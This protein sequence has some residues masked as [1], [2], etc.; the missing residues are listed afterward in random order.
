MKESGMTASGIS[1]V[2]GRNSSTVERF[3]IANG[4]TNEGNEVVFSSFEKSEI[5][6]LYEDERMNAVEVW[7][8]MFVNKCCKETVERYIRKTGMSRG[9]GRGSYNKTIVHDYFKEIDTPNKAYILGYTSA[10]GSVSSGKNV[11]FELTSEDVEILEFIK[12]E[13][14]INTSIHTYKREGRNDTCVLYASSIDLVKDLERYHVVTNKQGK[15]FPIPDIPEEYMRDFIR[16]YFDGDGSVFPRPDGT[17]RASICCSETFAFELESILLN[18]GILNSE[19]CNVVDMRKYGINI[20]SIRIDNQH[21]VEKFAKYIYRDNH[22]SLSR[23]R[24]R[25]TKHINRHANTEI[26]CS[27][28]VS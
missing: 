7:Q 23:K 8:Q 10:D 26:T 18:L 6:R 3:L 11:R 4:F 24:D 5:K 9:M 27:K 16:G 22:F 25:F 21:S 13:M 17:Y 20:F 28:Q 2:I 15:D 14:K 1:R 12:K 19:K